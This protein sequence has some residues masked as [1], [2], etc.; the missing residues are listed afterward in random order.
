MRAISI[1]REKK[2]A[3]ALIPYWCIF[4]FELRHFLNY[5]EN[6]GYVLNKD[7]MKNINYNLLDPRPYKKMPQDLDLDGFFDHPITKQLSDSIA[8][9]PVKNGDTLHVELPES[10]SELTIFIAAFTSTGVAF[11]NQVSVNDIK[12]TNKYSIVTKNSARTGI[13]LILSESSG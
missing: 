2:F 13:D 3:G 9:L 7:A 11:S 8:V 6:G 10:V 4:N 1:T 12:F 5:L